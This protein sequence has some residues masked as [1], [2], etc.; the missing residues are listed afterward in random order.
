MRQLITTVNVISLLYPGATPAPAPASA[1]A[2]IA[3]PLA[4]STARSSNSANQREKKI[5]R[6]A[7]RECVC[8]TM[9][10][11]TYS[12]R[13]NKQPQS[14]QLEIEGDEVSF[15]FFLLNLI[16]LVADYATPHR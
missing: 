11:G 14:V 6:T 7:Q 4:I 3:P 10:Y 2:T 16:Q 13:V 8:T 9:W 12:G 1:A 5:A 15:S